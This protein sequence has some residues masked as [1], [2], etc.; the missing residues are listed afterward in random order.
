MMRGLYGVW[1]SHEIYT[2]LA[3]LAMYSIVCI[4]DLIIV[5]L[6]PMLL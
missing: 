5:I 2:T 3:L 4:M 6:L 1:A